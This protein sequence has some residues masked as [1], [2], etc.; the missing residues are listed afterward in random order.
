M[1]SNQNPQNSPQPQQNGS[2]YTSYN[3]FAAEVRRYKS[4]I[5][6]DVVFVILTC[7]IYDLFWQY[8]QMKF[9]NYLL[10]ET[11][12]SFLRWFIF[13][14]LTCGLYN[15]FH[16]Y[17]MAKDIVSI[18]GKYSLE[19]SQ[20]LPAISVVM[21]VVSVGIIADAIQQYEMNQIIDRLTMNTGYATY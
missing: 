13:M 4:N 10:Q 20:D 2:N 8:R 19:K 1:E 7:G 15:L 12:F 3:E 5:A 18:Q 17:V 16:Q 14:I 11:K 21:S 6:L 9:V